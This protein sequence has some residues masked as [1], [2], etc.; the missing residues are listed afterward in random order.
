LSAGRDNRSVCARWTPVAAVPRHDDPRMARLGVGPARGRRPRRPRR[1]RPDRAGAVAAAWAPPVP[2]LR[3]GGAGR[4][5][6]WGG[7]PVAAQVGQTVLVRLDVRGWLPHWQRLR[8]VFAV[9]ATTW[10]MSP[11]FD[12]AVAGFVIVADAGWLAATLLKR[13]ARL[14]VGG[15]VACALG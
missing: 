6:Q 7:G 11:R 4:P 12:V 3:G 14:V 2:A 15:I 8:T 13:Q 5:R 10:A 9:A 1:R